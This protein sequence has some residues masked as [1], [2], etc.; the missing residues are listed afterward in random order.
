[1]NSK[2][3]IYVDMDGVLADFYSVYERLKRKHNIHQTGYVWGFFSR[4]VKEESLF[5]NL[6]M[7]PNA[8]LLLN[9]LSNI[10]MHFKDK[11][12]IKILTSGGDRSGTAH[13]EQAKQQK[14]E[15]LKK[16]NINWEAITV[17]I[18]DEKA[19]YA[20]PNSILIDDTTSN[21]AQFN[22]AGG[23]GILYSD[24]FS[25]EARWEISN[26]VINMTMPV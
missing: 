8:N 6:P 15:W 14:E 3:I 23:H 11:V 25:D 9:H 4:M 26:S 22:A 21:I 17:K 16:H 5:T 2:I 24:E 18:K 12:V 7:L 10:E 20:N 1:M 13:Y 19:A